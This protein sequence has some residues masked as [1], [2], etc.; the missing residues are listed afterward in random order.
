MQS[1]NEREIMRDYHD[2]QIYRTSQPDRI[3]V[4]LVVFMGWVFIQLL[5]RSF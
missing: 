1:T 3:L 4:L 2:K 5:L